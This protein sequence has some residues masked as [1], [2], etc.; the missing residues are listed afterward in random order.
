MNINKFCLTTLMVLC[1]A[2][3]SSAEDARW[4]SWRGPLA[5]GIIPDGNPPITWSE[6]ENIQW[7]I[8]LTGDGSNSTPVIWGD[9]LIYQNAV[10]TDKQKSQTETPT[11][12]PQPA[13]QGGRRSGRGASPT[14]YYR[15]NLICRNRHTG[16][17]IW[18]K[19]VAEVVPQQGHHADHGFVS[20]SPITDGQHIWA[21]FGPQGLHCYDLDGNAKWKIELGP[22]NV[23]SGFGPGGSL[24]LID[25]MIIVVKDHEDQSFIVALNKDSGQEIWKKLRDEPS[26]WT[27]PLAVTVQGQTQIV[28]NGHNRVLA[29]HA[30]NGD[31]IWEST[32]QTL[33]V[34]PT[35][36]LS[37]DMIFCASGFR[38]S[39]LQAIKLGRTGKLTGTDAIVWEVDKNTP[40]VPSPLCYQNRVYV[41]SVSTQRISCFD[42]PTGKAHYTNESLPEVK[43]IYAS[44]I[45]VAGHVYFVGRNGVTAVLKNADSLDVVA[46]N[47]LDDKIDCSPV[48]I[49]D[50]LYLKGKKN[51]YCIAE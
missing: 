17:L 33:N 43:G 7:K 34:I 21:N 8:E 28:V 44:P 29:Y 6:T 13:A 42:A 20:F 4:P 48:V 12:T 35:P 45:G 27:T 41:C 11:P 31:V 51:L 5:T 22:Y 26:A 50:T 14:N 24:A 30:S 36:V 47:T 18:S 15:F 19:T 38:G 2:T 39:K 3:F 40:Y 46:T 23:R 16:A 37:D 9:K 49:G 1:L 32:G 25:D 10:K